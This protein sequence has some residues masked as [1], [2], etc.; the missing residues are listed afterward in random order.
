MIYHP[1]TDLGVQRF[2]EDWRKVDRLS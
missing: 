2:I 1:L